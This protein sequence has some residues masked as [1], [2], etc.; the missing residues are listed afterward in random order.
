MA[1]NELFGQI[2]AEL[3]A[4][5]LCEH[6]ELVEDVAGVVLGESVEVEEE[7]IEASPQLPPLGQ[8]PD[9]SLTCRKGQHF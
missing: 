4:L 2:V 3:L 6:G 1:Q 9:G 8:I 5:V 7:C